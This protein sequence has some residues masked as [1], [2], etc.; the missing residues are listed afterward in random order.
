MRMNAVL[1]TVM[2]L[3]GVAVANASGIVI[4]DKNLVIKNGG[5]D[6]RGSPIYSSTLNILATSAKFAGSIVAPYISATQISSNTICVGTSTCATPLAVVGDANFG[7]DVII[8]T[9]PKCQYIYTTNTG[10]LH[11]GN[12]GE[13][14]QVDGSTLEINTTYTDNRYVNVTGDTMSGTLA[15]PAIHISGSITTPN[16]SYL[17]IGGEANSII[18]SFPRVASSNDN[19]FLYA[20]QS[21]PNA[22]DLRLYLQDDQDDSERFSIWGGSCS[23]GGCSQGTANA[24]VQHYWTA[25]GNAYHRG[26]L[27]VGGTTTT[28]NLVLSGL[29]NCNGKLYTDASGKV[30]CGTDNAGVTGSGTVNY[31]PKFTGSTTLGNSAIYQTPEG[32][33]GIGTTAPKYTLDVNGSIHAQ[34]ICLED[35]CRSSWSSNQSEAPKQIYCVAADGK[36]YYL[37]E[38]SEIRFHAGS[39]TTSTGSTTPLG[40]MIFVDTNGN[41][42]ISGA[43]GYVYRNKTKFAISSK[44]LGGFY[45]SEDSATQACKCIGSGWELNSALQLQCNDYTV[46]HVYASCKEVSLTCASGTDIYTDLSC[47]LWCKSIVIK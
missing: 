30:V 42:W 8:S 34:E 4:S 6:L 18:V 22:Y 25:A 19:A 10:A 35:S 17:T 45:D 26:N 3:M 14:I 47:A 43:D 39:Y 13:G 28:Q 15:V 38:L 32:N 9:M 11:C 27:T 31:I 12:I 21:G 46:T 37:G 29:K 16:G 20:Y 41:E 44:Q 7:G 23:N 1:F 24:V 33:I 2:V 36:E 5:L 40:N